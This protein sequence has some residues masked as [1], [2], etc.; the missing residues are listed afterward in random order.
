MRYVHLN[1]NWGPNLW[2]KTNVYR[3][4]FS[5]KNNED[6]FL[7]R[8]NPADHKEDDAVLDS[9]EGSGDDDVSSGT[10][11]LASS[12]QWIS[13]DWLLMLKQNLVCLQSGRD[14]RGLRVGSQE[15]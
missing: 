5:E 7:H 15:E 2:L 12:E 13:L 3:A 1:S 11:V 10:M 4:P 14:G 8:Y 6:A 9:D